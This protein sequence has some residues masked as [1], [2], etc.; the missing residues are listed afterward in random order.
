MLFHWA[1]FIL[2]SCRLNGHGDDV[3][4]YDALVDA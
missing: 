1:M 2:L 4:S 3:M